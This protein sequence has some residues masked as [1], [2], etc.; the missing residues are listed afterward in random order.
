MMNFENVV[1]DNLTTA[2]EDV[3]TGSGFVEFSYRAEDALIRR[4][5]I[6]Q[7]RDVIKQA[8]DKT[9]GDMTR[10]LVLK[11]ERINMIID[12]IVKEENDIMRVGK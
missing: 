3:M 2:S 10:S 12:E 5:A 7:A 6:N 8:I 11:Y 9:H 1:K 4:N